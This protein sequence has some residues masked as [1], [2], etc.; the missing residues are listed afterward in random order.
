MKR[1]VFLCFMLV[2]A[3]GLTLPNLISANRK[4]SRPEVQRSS[5]M[6]PEC[7]VEAG[8][9]A[10]RARRAAQE[11]RAVTALLPE[12]EPGTAPA[13]MLSA[14]ALAETSD[15]L[16]D[17]EI[18]AAL[19]K[20]SIQPA[21]EATDEEFCRRVYFDLTGKQPSPD[22]LTAYLNN[23]DAQKKEKLVNTLIG[24]PAFI[25]R[26][27]NWMGDLLHM[28]VVD[29]GTPKDRNFVYSY[30]RNA[31]AKNKPFDQI[32]TDFITYTGRAD[33]GPGNFL[34]QPMYFALAEGGPRQDAF[35]EAAAETV[36]TFL[37]V[38]AVCISCHDGAGH[39]ESINLH[40]AESKRAAYWGIA[41]H[42]AQ[43][44]FA[45]DDN[46]T[47]G[48]IFISKR[49]AAGKYDANTQDGTGMRPGRSGGVIQ[50]SFALFGGTV[51][52]SS[53]D[54]RVALAR[55]ITKSPQFSRA[56][57]NRMFAY[58]FTLGL[59]EPVDQFDLARQNINNPP[60]AP[61]DLQPSNPVLLNRLA[62]FF[63]ASNYDMAALMRLMVLSKAYGLS[64]RYDESKWNE[65]YAPL[66]ARKLVRRL[67]AEE[68]FDAIAFATEVPGLFYAFGIDT[69]FTSTMSLPGPEDPVYLEGKQVPRDISEDPYSVHTFL[70]LFGRGNRNTVGRSNRSSLGNALQL[71]NNYDTVLS[72]V[73]PFGYY[74]V[75]RNGL[76]VQLNKALST[77]STNLQSAIEKLFLKTLARRPTA[78]E[79]K[80]LKIRAAG[81]QFASDLQWALLNR[82]DFLYN[83]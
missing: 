80:K 69:P 60:P 52:N 6:R 45:S 12:P 43:M 68:V 29:G 73:Y 79:T 47:N 40:L 71:F 30:L 21:A 22:E 10:M 66:Y 78:A 58:F 35:D 3:L 5:R 77:R 81:T 38:Q 54:P 34:R 65:T 28:H 15:N 16:I 23:K 14:K 55:S 44:D 1:I 19:A 67:Q 72:R 32:A 26:W 42:F 36:R 61:W 48:F 2:V 24:S 62:D 41:A 76:A 70:D 11:T 56:F 13:K 33:Q 39:L 59:V 46:E 20:K 18:F 27:T 8:T 83:Y 63:Q 82:V 50:P 9:P 49:N 53:E 25:D 64:S 31:L 74:N 51:A 75:Q 17:Q 57:A 7:M 4:M 37:G